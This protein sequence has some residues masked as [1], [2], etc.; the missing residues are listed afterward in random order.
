MPLLVR[1]GLARRH[2]PPA[3]VDPRDGLDRPTLMQ[4][5]WGEGLLV[6]GGPDHIVS[7]VEPLHLGRSSTLVDLAAGLGGPARAIAKATNAWVTG[8]ERSPDIARRAMTLSEGLGMGKRAPVM[9]YS[10]EGLELEEA[11]FDSV[12]ARFATW[13]LA[14]KERLLRIAAAGLARDGRLLLVDYAAG[15]MNPATAWTEAAG[16]RDVLWS[17]DQYADCLGG[18]GLDLLFSVD[19][20]PIHRGFVRR[21]W[22]GLADRLEDVA[23]EDLALVGVEA[24]RWTLEAEAIDAGELRVI[25]MLATKSR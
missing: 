7:L 10:P 21:G 12:L 16:A 4:R 24:R 13:E 17:E 14:H 1:L 25:C 15:S 9:A 8:L 6:P 11:A 5:L 23:R 20:S 3:K 18:T 22:E 2:R 19:M